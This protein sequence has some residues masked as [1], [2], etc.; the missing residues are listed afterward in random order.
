MAFGEPDGG[1][2]PT[3]TITVYDYPPD[4]IHAKTT[5]EG[6][7]IEA[8]TSIFKAAGIHYSWFPT[9]L[10][11][12]SA[13]L[14]DGNRPF[15]T[16]GRIY[17]AERA[18][19]WAYL[20][21]IMFRVTSDALLVH[22]DNL[23]KF[24]AF[25]S[26]LEIVRSDTLKGAFVQHGSYGNEIDALLKQQVPWLNQTAQTATQ[27]ML[28]VA[29]GRADYTIVVTSRWQSEK[30]SNPSLKSLVNI[31]SLITEETPT[32][33]YMTCSKSVP[34]PILEKLAL[35]MKKLGF[36]LPEIPINSTIAR[37]VMEKE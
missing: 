10:G 21:R 35:A 22:E 37:P 12:E 18:K 24:D 8:T 17:T 31:M 23:Q 4:I 6:P 14:N 7:L 28:M 13:M 11:A 2:H 5:P 27:T 30:K 9:T 25:S 15:C 29:A 26:F 33:V 1:K 20:P 36:Q 32:P 34:V 19:K 3:L 16:T